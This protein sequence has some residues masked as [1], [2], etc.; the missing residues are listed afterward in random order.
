MVKGKRRCE[1]VD[2]VKLSCP[3]FGVDNEVTSALEKFNADSVITL[4]IACIHSTRL[5]LPATLISHPIFTL[6]SNCGLL[7]CCNEVQCKLEEDHTSS[8]IWA[9]CGLLDTIL[10]SPALGISLFL[11]LSEQVISGT[12]PSLIVVQC[13]LLHCCNLA[14]WACPTALL[15]ATNNKDHRA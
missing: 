4:Q 3:A 10:N 2:I 13:Y 6:I 15:S 5:P 9:H 7:H 1:V 8:S 12:H 14:C 11:S